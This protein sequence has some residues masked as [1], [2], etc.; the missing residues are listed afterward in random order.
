MTENLEKQMSFIRETDRMKGILRANM[1]LDGSR[2]EDDAQHSWHV[3]LMA[4]V[5]K[6]YAGPKVKID[7]AI[8]MLLVHDLVE[9]DAGDTYAYDEKAILDKGEREHKAARRVFGILPSPQGDELRALWEEFEACQTPTSVYANAIDR[10]QPL[11][12]NFW[13]DGKVWEENDITL[14]KVLKRNEITKEAMPQ[15]WD[16]VWELLTEA[17]NRGYLR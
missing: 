17:K 16:A 3:A 6:E 10:L 2:N 1:M 15:I 8:R 13:V 7:H 9:I 4:L 12:G 5:M 14:E 11:W